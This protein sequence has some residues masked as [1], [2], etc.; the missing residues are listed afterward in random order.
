MEVKI[1]NKNNFPKGH[2]IRKHKEKRGRQKKAQKLR[3]QL[4][5]CLKTELKKNDLRV[6]GTREDVY[7]P[8]TTVVLDGKSGNFLLN[9]KYS[10]NRDKLSLYKGSRI[11]RGSL[12][13]QRQRRGQNTTRPAWL[14][15]NISNLID[16]IEGE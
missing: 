4:L 9:L 12:L 6:R 8:A 16:K 13:E 11:R 7:P 15:K 5:Q 14:N 2:P 10:K 3:N 1:V